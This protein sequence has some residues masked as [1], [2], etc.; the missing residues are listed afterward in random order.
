MITSLGDIR[1]VLADADP[2]D[3]ADVYQNLGLKLTYYPANSLCGPRLSSTRTSWGYGLCPRSELNHKPN[4]S[5][6]GPIFNSS[7]AV[8]EATERKRP[9]SAHR[10]IDRNH[11]SR[12]TGLTR[13][14][15]QHEA[16]TAA[17]T[18]DLPRDTAA[19]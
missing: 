9:P 16:P 7:G 10:R 11:P 17:A 2:Q 15:G 14:A 1:D 4:R 5:Y 18:A 6:C 13:G 12:T 19:A 8:G 3:K